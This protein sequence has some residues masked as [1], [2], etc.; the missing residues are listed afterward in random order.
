MDGLGATYVY[1]F[2]PR[3]SQ[4][5]E[6]AKLTVPDPV[7]CVSY[8]F[9]KNVSLDGDVAL[10]GSEAIYPFGCGGGGQQLN[11]GAYVFRFD[12]EGWVFETKL[13]SSDLTFGDRFGFSVAIDGDLALLGAW[14]VWDPSIPCSAV[15]P[16]SDLCNAGSAYVFAF[17]GTEWVEQARLISS[18]IAEADQLGWSV[19]LSG[20]TALVGAFGNEDAGY[21]TGSA[22]F[23]GGLADCNNNDVLD[24]CDI[25]DGNSDDD[26]NNG[27][28]DECESPPCPWD[29]DNTGTVGASDLLS[30]LVS[31]GPCKGCPAD[32]DGNGSVGASDLLALLVNWGPCP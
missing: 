2:D 24:L 16:D 4:W 20:E 1:R 29:L 11:D 19:A 9:G 23:F 18:D 7:R 27:I 8:R 21:L 25:V 26:N 6:E 14:G 22:Y 10:I 17:D 30:L 13:V 12:P 15:P 31:W 3:N 32:F 28:P 5:T